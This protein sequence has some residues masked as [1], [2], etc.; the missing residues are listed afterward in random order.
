MVTYKILVSGRVQGVSFRAFIYQNAIRLGLKGYVKNLSDGRVEVIAS[1]NKV[2]I[3][4]LI[5]I[6]RKGNNWSHVENVE[7]K[8]IS[9]ENFNEFEIR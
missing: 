4:E 7:A 5:E 2:K 1:G 8:E 3:N 9:N 6:C